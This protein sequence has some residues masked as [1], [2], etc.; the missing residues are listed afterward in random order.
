MTLINPHINF[1]G[2]AEEAFYK[3]S[4]WR[5]VCIEGSWKAREFEFRDKNNSIGFWATPSNNK[6][7]V[8]KNFNDRQQVIFVK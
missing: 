4:I 1:N 3:I 6:L 7:E 5:R 2:D 8:G